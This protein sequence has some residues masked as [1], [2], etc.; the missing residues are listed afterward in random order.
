MSISSVS[1]LRIVVFCFDSKFCF[2]DGVSLVDVVMPFGDLPD[3]VVCD[4]VESKMSR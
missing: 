2:D 3:F 1:L 4:G